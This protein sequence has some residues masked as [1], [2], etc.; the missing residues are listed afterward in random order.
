MN[1]N[2]LKKAIRKINPNSFFRSELIRKVSIR[3]VI[4]NK[5]TVVKSTII[6]PTIIK[7]AT[8]KNL[9][10]ITPKSTFTKSTTK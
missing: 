2:N 10:I 5:V 7:S 4:A 6:T 1:L 9:V 3:K 8:T